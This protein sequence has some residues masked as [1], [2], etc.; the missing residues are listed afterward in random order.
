MSGPPG[1][2][3]KTTLAHEIARAVGCPAICRD[4]IKEGMVHAN[5]GFVPGPGDPLTERVFPLFFD[6]LAMLVGA[7]VSVVAEAA[8]QGP[9]W[10]PGLER[11]AR[12]A[13]LR[14][15]QCIV[16]PDIAHARNMQRAKENPLR[17]A[18]HGMRSAQRSG[19][20]RPYAYD[21]ISMDAPV[22]HVDTTNGYRPALPGIVAFAGGRHHVPG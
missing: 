17:R 4:E 5:P 18:A 7:G 15:L 19:E 8:F 12:L 10:R 13:D 21:P 1:G 22:L 14:V 2:F 6:V 16:D 11:L 3:G 20:P 9:V